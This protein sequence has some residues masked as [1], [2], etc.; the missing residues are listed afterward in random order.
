[1]GHTLVLHT[2]PLG[3]VKVQ[4]Q[5]YCVSQSAPHMKERNFYN[6]S[7]ANTK[8][9][10]LTAAQYTYTVLVYRIPHISCP[11]KTPAND[12]VLGNIHAHRHMT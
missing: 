5:G 9:A 10:R 7:M 6:R 4:L 3:E 8:T 1:M 12:I 2:T 11:T